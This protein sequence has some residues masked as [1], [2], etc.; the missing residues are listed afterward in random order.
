MEQLGDAEP[1][2]HAV[3]QALAVQVV[4]PDSLLSE[5]GVAMLAFAE[6][7]NSIAN[8]GDTRYIGSANRRHCPVN[9]SIA[10][11]ANE[12][13]CLMYQRF[14]QNDRSS[15]QSNQRSCQKHGERD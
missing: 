12:Q 14:C 15:C 5:F 10:D 6:M 3:L 8:L 2:F 1:A 13:Q 9:D 11:A 4:L 7:A